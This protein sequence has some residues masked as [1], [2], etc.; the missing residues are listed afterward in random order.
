MWEGFPLGRQ[1]GRT[2]NNEGRYMQ[3]GAAAAAASCRGWGGGG[4]GGAVNSICSAM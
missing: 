3:F 1:K 2:K 4:G